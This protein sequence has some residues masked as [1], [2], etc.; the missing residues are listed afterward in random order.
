MEYRSALALA[1]GLGSAKDGINHWWWQRVTAVFLIPLF[2]W[3]TF[4]MITVSSYA[5]PDVINLFS[6]PLVAIGLTLLTTFVYFHAFLGLQ[7]VIE[8]YV[9]ANKTKIASLIILKGFLFTLSIATVFAIV[10][11]HFMS[12]ATN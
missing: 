1:R 6:S 8:D 3:F 12:F 7:V 4:S 5:L 11:L 9:H 2:I 10:K